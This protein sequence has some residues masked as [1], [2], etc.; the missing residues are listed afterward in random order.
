MQRVVILGRGASGK[1]TLARALGAVT[2]L[3]VLE[4]DNSSGSLTCF[5][6]SRVSWIGFKSSST[7]ASNGSQQ[8]LDA[9]V[10]E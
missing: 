8:W 6:R 10:I 4:L 7:A 9:C 5:P 3:A 1:S 2:N